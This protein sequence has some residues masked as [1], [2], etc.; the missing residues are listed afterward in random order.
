MPA[1]PR[2]FDDAVPRS[3]ARSRA[4]AIVDR[5]RD[6][7]ERAIGDKSRR[8]LIRILLG[9]QKQIGEA[10]RK[11]HP[12]AT[13]THLDLEQTM[14][15]VTEALSSTGTTSK[16][17]RELLEKQREQAYAVGAKSTAEML[18]H[19]EGGKDNGTIRPLAIRE[20]LAMKRM[21]LDEHATS[22]DR[23]GK[24][25]IGVIRRELQSGIVRGA[26]FH[27]MTDLLVGKR[28]PR[29]PKV[30]LAATVD[31]DGKVRRL[32]EGRF[33]KG[34]FVE[35]RGWAERIVRTEGMRAYAA[36]ADEEI[37]RQKAHAFS[38]LARKIVATF[39]SRTA[40]DSRNV[41]GQVRDVGQP[42]FDGIRTYLRPP[43]R[44]NDRECLIPW[45]AVWAGKDGKGGAD[46]EGEL[47]AEELAILNRAG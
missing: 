42:F 17:F 45:R 32:Q 34:L 29:G 43:A 12:D 26:T 14:R 31:A 19:F 7:V 18:T 11:T 35:R 22:V 46:E 25:M 24:H 20:A 3:R 41:H 2:S 33:D 8:D 9:A 5:N 47:T 44:P 16:A 23:Y 30:S 27:E 1:S 39:D 36:G 40:Q 28:G 4:Q 38:D 10:Q 15:V 13:W 21:A 37:A 6:E